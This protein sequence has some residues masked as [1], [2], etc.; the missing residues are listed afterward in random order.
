MS[1]YSYYLILNFLHTV[2]LNDAIFLKK[3][4]EKKK[5]FFSNKNI[6]FNKRI[7]KELNKIDAFKNKC[8]TLT[9]LIPNKKCKNQ[10]E[11][12]YFQGNFSLYEDKNLFPQYKTKQVEICK[13]SKFITAFKHLM[14]KIDV[15][16]Q[17]NITLVDNKNLS[18]TPYQYSNIMLYQFIN[19]GAEK[20]YKELYSFQIIGKNSHALFFLG[21]ENYYLR[22]KKFLKKFGKK[23]FNFLTDVYILPYEKD[24]VYK[25]FKNYKLNTKDLWLIKPDYGTRGMGIEFF[26]TLKNLPKRTTL[27]KYI[28]NPLLINKRKFDMRIYTLVT[29]MNPLKIYIYNEG[30]VKIAAEKYTTDLNSLNNNQT[31]LTHR[32]VN[33]NHSQFFISTDP[34][35]PEG[36]FWPMSTFM[37][38]LKEKGIDTEK[39]WKDM[40]DSLIKHYILFVDDIIKYDKANN[41]T[42]K[43]SYHLWGA[44]IMLTEKYETIILENNICSRLYWHTDWDG[45]IGAQMLKDLFN[46]VGISS[47]DREDPN[48]YNHKRT[49]EEVIDDSI[50]EF[51]RPHGGFYRIFP[52][53][54]NVK[55]YKKYLPKTKENL[56]LW[57]AMKKAGIK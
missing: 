24:I 10:R 47:Y 53:I 28:L 55:K 18:T 19:K 36:N 23:E 25:K 21:K 4:K 56:S 44:D 17:S 37:K 6:Q 45:K 32:F 22:Y 43:N 57:K 50:C 5:K 3:R 8:Q 29:G 7:E 30:Y 11:T 9:M 16:N 1:V 2:F 13:K 40:Y 54:S 49:L 26:R 48:I 38:Y 52:R 51:T 20:A 42:Y 46:I 34:K 41:Y 39:I 33:S 35:K 15:F 27:M 31:H 14:P 12:V